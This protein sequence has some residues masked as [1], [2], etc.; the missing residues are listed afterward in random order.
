MHTPTGKIGEMEE[1]QKE[2]G[3]D[4]VV[5]IPNGKE[6]HGIIS[7][8]GLKKRQRYNELMKTGASN[9]E[10]FD[11]VENYKGI[12]PDKYCGEITFADDFEMSMTNSV[13]GETKVM[14]EGKDYTIK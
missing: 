11:V 1:M 9:D 6:E 10:A 4:N 5:S 14:E 3:A 13:T 12:I 8:W 2:F 7:K